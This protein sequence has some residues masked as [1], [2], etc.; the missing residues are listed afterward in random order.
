MLQSQWT[1]G[2]QTYSLLASHYLISLAHKLQ[3][4]KINQLLLSI[5][6]ERLW[7]ST[8]RDSPV[9]TPSEAAH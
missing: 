9:A 1:G 6:K 5:R 2:L 8:A 7:A 4:L 3:L